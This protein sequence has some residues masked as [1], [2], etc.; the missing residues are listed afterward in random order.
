MLCIFKAYTIFKWKFLENVERKRNH[1]LVQNGFA[2]SLLLQLE[3]VSYACA[4]LFRTSQASGR[5]QTY[6]W[7][8]KIIDIS[9]LS[10]IVCF[11]LVVIKWIYKQCIRSFKWFKCIL[12]EITF[13]LTF[14]IHTAE[15]LSLN[16]HIFSGFLQLQIS[17]KI[18]YYCLLH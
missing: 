8:T 4:H 15:I 18:N 16:V 3:D 6:I 13:T 1:R 11:F 14:I 9:V 2:I 10:I 7:K 5:H 12:W 17:E